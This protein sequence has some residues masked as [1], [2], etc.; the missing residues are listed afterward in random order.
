MN[1]NMSMNYESLKNK[2]YLKLSNIFIIVFI[3]IRKIDTNKKI[4][5]LTILSLNNNALLFCL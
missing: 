3:F 4:L 1:M 5:S 2:I